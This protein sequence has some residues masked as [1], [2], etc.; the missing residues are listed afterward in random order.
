MTVT[1]QLESS[2]H[3][4]YD[5]YHLNNQFKKGNDQTTT[6]QKLRFIQVN[7]FFHLSYLI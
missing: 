1:S 7:T 4:L 6:I 5:R 2:I 3:S